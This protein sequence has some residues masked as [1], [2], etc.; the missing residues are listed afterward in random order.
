MGKS[1]ILSTHTEDELTVRIE[2][3]LISLGFAICHSTGSGSLSNTG[4]AAE[5]FSSSSFCT[6]VCVDICVCVCV[7]VCEHVCVNMCV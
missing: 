5:G 2:Y 1:I 4:L 7:C 6:C 3:S